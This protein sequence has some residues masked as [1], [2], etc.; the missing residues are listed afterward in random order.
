[1]KKWLSLLLPLI[2]LTIFAWIVYGTGVDQILE[3]FR[4]VEP[5]RL[6][7]FPVFTLGMLFLRGLRWKHLMAMIGIEYPLWKSGVVWAIGYFGASVT[8]GKVGDAVRAVYLSRDTQRPFAESFLT[9]FVDRLL[10]LM[11]VLVLGMITILVFSHNYM[12]FPSIWI[13]VTAV[14]VVMAVLAVA[15]NRTLVKRLI[16]P[17]F[18]VLAPKRFKDELSSQFEQFYDSLGMYARQPGKMMVAVLYT[19]VYWFCVLLLAYTVTRVLNINVSFAYMTLLM[20]IITL[21]ELVPISIAGLGPRDA[22]TIFFFAVIG[23]PSPEA[24]GFSILYLLG[25]TYVTALVGFVAWL[26]RPTK[27]A[28]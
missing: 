10:D 17:V 5:K 4:G 20:P 6:L 15:L 18:R 27:L 21:V 9:V 16:G 24:V 11:T 25:G 1:M 14:L 7:I 13:V 3:T 22:T 26:T 8:P 19:L 12:R 2:G 28:G 23:I